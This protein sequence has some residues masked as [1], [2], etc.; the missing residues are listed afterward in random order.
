LKKDSNRRRSYQQAVEVLCRDFED[1]RTRIKDSDKAEWDEHCRVVGSAKLFSKE[2]YE[3]VQAL[4]L[5]AAAKVPSGLGLGT[6]MGDARWPSAPTPASVGWVC[7]DGRCSRAVLREGSVQ[8][9]PLCALTTKPMH[10][11]G[12]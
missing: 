1:L 7:P 9:A 4:Q 6:T 12:G 10:L 5:A 11:V 2:W 8:A 3:A